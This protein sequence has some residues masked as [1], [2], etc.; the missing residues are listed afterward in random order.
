VHGYKPG[1]LIS[2]FGITREQLR[3]WRRELDPMPSRPLFSYQMLLGYAVIR[4]LILGRWIEPRRLKGVD[5][6]A[7][8]GWFEHQHSAQELKMTVI[9]INTYS[10]TLNFYTLDDFQRKGL[11]NE[12]SIEAV[13]LNKVEE[14]LLSRFR[15]FGV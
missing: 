11:A 14:Q 3:Y 12:V 1:L 15:E 13:Y 9:A 8:F 7:F 5:L 6:K 10:S 4:E 2:L